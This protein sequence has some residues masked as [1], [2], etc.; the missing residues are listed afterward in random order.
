MKTTLLALVLL[1]ATS[2]AAVSQ[3]AQVD[4]LEGVAHIEVGGSWS[5]LAIGDRLPPEATIR[6]SE[7][8]FLELVQG[9]LR[10][11]ITQDGLY[12]L[13]D[14]IG[15]SRQVAAWDL[16]NSVSGKLKGAVAGPRIGGDTAMGV[17]GSAAG[18]AG[19]IQWLEA[20]ET[21]EIVSRGREL[22]G[23]G[24]YAEALEV[25][26]EGYQ[27]AGA[28]DREVFLY[29]IA[30]GHSEQGR[31]G[32]ALAALRGVQPDPGSQVFADL[33]LLQGRLLVESLAFQDALELFDRQ[34]ARQPSA[35]LAQ[36]ML[37]MSAYCHRGLGDAPKVRQ[38]LTRARDL[39][40]GSELGREADNLLR[41]L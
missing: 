26:E 20:D 14:V 1:A 18:S 19:D 7:Q 23:R 9:A 15:K 11:S 36:A 4:Y 13:S 33:V 24:R 22:L 21:E 39:D 30:L 10:V 27:N 6:L 12:K 2:I 40:W 3:V 37:I 28:Q 8:G 5:E 16:K 41:G 34:L 31:T 17:R 25:F 38:T 29:Y 35:P 32:R